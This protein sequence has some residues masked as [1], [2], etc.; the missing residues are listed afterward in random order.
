METKIDGKKIIIQ[1]ERSPVMGF[2]MGGLMV[3]I[4]LLFFLARPFGSVIDWLIVLGM[5][6][7]GAAMIKF[8]GIDDMGG[9]F[10]VWTIDLEKKALV[11]DVSDAVTEFPFDTIE[12]G[13][14]VQTSP[15]GGQPFLKIK[16]SDEPGRIPG[17]HQRPLEEV[18]LLIPPLNAAIG[19]NAEMP[20]LCQRADEWMK[21]VEEAI[22]A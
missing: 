21:Q 2:V 22:K 8:M 14:I 9:K 3:A 13:I 15:E 12:A 4:A 19:A 20:E 5:G 16:G 11:T 10:D 17:F 7:V 6:G 1:E 18:E